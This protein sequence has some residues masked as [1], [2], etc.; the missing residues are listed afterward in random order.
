MVQNTKTLKGKTVAITRP[1]EQAKE[2]GKLIKQKGGKPYFLPTIEIKGPPDLAVVK[3][4]VEQL[5]TGLVDYVIFMSVNGV[6]HLLHA[7]D[8]LGLKGKLKTRLNKVV[9]MAVGPKTAEAMEKNKIHVSLVPAKYTSEGILQT[10]MEHDTVGKVI[11]IPRTRQAPPELADT[12]RVMGNRV[13][14]IYVYESKLPSNKKLNGK[15]LKD[16]SEGR[17]DAIIFSSSLG[18]R[19]LFD[20]L[21]E[22]VPAEKL[23]KLIKP[24]TTVVAIGPTTAKTL[25][26]L[27]LN[28][29]VMPEKHLF[30]DALDALA[31][32]WS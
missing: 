5:A 13:V 6:Q 1:R 3:N 26:D 2:A 9:T 7:A 17:I 8:K 10:L 31:D 25:H 27:G 15:F 19:N 21:A 32:Y 30:E 28:V 11:Y 23:A 22:D 4:F 16:L 29:D 12:L 14:E 24:K 20:M 18:T